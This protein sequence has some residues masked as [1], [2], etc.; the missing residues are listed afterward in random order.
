VEIR[1]KDP[2]PCGSGKKYKNCHMKDE[3]K[4]KSSRQFLFLL[5]PIL[6]L[7]VGAILWSQRS[8]RPTV[9][10]ALTGQTGS[11]QTASPDQSPLPDGRTPV[12]WEFD[13][14]R[15]RYWDPNH[16]H[17]HIGQP[18]PE[19]QRRIGPPPNAPTSTNANFPNPE[20]WQFD[21]E[22]NQHFDPD[23]RHWHSGPPPPEDQRTVS[24]GP[25]TTT[26]TSSTGQNPDFPN[27]EPY[28]Y[29]AAKDQ[30]YD[31]NHG[32]WHRGRPAADQ[33]GAA[34]QTP[35]TESEGTGP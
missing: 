21:P 13:S 22:T 4:K 5:I 34:P 20:P 28:Q 29:D 16:N 12:A 9:Q 1:S 7:G 35:A 8:D 18:P 15:N 24:S 23:H 25:V 30:H 3:H 32:H 10:Q 2:C 31:P 26:T 6:V 14:P 17:W 33:T 19:D 27:P 11:S